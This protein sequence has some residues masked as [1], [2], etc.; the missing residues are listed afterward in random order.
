MPKSN[1]LHHN[2]CKG[3]EPS[4]T[5]REGGADSLTMQARAQ[6]GQTDGAR[7]LP[8]AVVGPLGMWVPAE[9]YLWPADAGNI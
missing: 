5:C 6:G 1:T 9:L 2:D 3:Q 7:T 4:T 8:F